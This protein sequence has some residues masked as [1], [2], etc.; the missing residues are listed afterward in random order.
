MSDGMRI[1]NAGVR[2]LAGMMPA[3]CETRDMSTPELKLTAA[4]AEFE[5]LRAEILSIRQVKRNILS[6]ALAAYAA[7][8]SFA[9]GKGGDPS[10]LLV[11]PPLGLVLCWFELSET[12]QIDRIAEYIRD[13]VWP[14]IGEL[15]DYRHSW[16]TRHD[17]LSTCRK[18]LLGILLDGAFPLMSVGVSTA[19]IWATWEVSSTAAV[20]ARICAVLLA[21]P[22][23][24]YGGYVLASYKKKASTTEG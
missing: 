20:F 8:F 13:Q 9:L 1:G 2:N 24:F 10:L 14:E 15:T 4:M 7:I 3:R 11:V 22:S 23:L 18:A 12:I 21:A 5:A 19:A 17:H 6:V 16:E